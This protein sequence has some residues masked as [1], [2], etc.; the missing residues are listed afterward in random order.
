M[1]G[2]TVS[3]A[4]AG[5]T[6]V[7]IRAA[8]TTRGR[9]A[10]HAS[11]R[12]VPTLSSFGTLPCW[13]GRAARSRTHART[14]PASVRTERSPATALRAVRRRSRA[15]AVSSAQATKTQGKSLG[16][17]A[18]PVAAHAAGRSA[19]PAEMSAAAGT[20]AAAPGKGVEAIGART[21]AVHQADTWAGSRS[22]VL[23]APSP[24]RRPSR[25]ARPETPHAARKN[26]SSVR[27]ATRERARTYDA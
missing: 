3:A 7:A 2:S 27:F 19:A 17:S 22:A 21:C 1:P 25:A 12:A 26:A 8:R 24:I 18:A 23:P 14:A 10:S 6:S 16:R 13:R 4:T 15:S 20:S 11:R 5:S 9:T